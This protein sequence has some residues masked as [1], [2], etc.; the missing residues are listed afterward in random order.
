MHCNNGAGDE[1]FAPRT[2]TDAVEGLLEAL[3]HKA[4]ASHTH[5]ITDVNGLAD[6]LNGK[7]PLSHNHNMDD[8]TGLMEALAE[9]VS[10]VVTQAVSAAKLAAYPVG[11]YYLSDAEDDPGTLF[12]G[13]WERVKDSFLLAAGDAFTAGTT[14]GESAHTLTTE[15][16]PAHGHPV[17]GSDGRYV[18]MLNQ[19]AANT[20]DG[21]FVSATSGGVLFRWTPNWISANAGGGKPHNNMP[22]YLAVYMWR[23]VA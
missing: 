15:E 21:R 16:L 7:A 2:T 6:T 5:Q 20:A 11:S 4:D 9:A 3:T 22:P 8:I 17:P 23:R 13:S 1:R 19:A 10:G 14:G 18:T 12:G